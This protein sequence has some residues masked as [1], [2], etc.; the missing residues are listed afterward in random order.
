[1]TRTTIRLGTAISPPTGPQSQSQNT[2]VTKTASGL[3]VRVL[4]TACGVT[5][6]LST[7]LSPR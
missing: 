1:M 3:S 4:P 7:V 2:M 6:W 5:N